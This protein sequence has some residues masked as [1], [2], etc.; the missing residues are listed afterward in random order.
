MAEPVFSKNTAR[1]PDLAPER[2][3]A[4]LNTTA[5]KVGNAVGS[6]VDTVRHLP[7][8]L[9]E[10]KER[11]TVIRGRAKDEAISKAEELKDEAKLKAVEA[12]NRAQRL[13]HDYPLHT[14]LG[15]AGIG[16]II[17]VGLRIWR[18]YAD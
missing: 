11:F 14:I 12:R 8:R 9:Q 4:A 5:E 13:A 1:Y 3:N 10:M 16:F 2:S 6:A 7:D 17:G 15:A 18:N